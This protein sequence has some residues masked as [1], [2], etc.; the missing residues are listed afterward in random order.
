MYDAMYDAIHGWM[1]GWTDGWMDGKSFT[2]MTS[3]TVCNFKNWDLMPT[4]LS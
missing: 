4:F 1:T 3:F 2:T